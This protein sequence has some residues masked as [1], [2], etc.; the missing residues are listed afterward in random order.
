MFLKI[1][2]EKKNHQKNPCHILFKNALF[3]S[4]ICWFLKT[5]TR[6]S[7][8]HD[9]WSILL[10]Y[11]PTWPSV[12][13]LWPFP[14]QQQPK[15][16]FKGMLFARSSSIDNH[17]FWANEKICNKIFWS[18]IIHTCSTTIPELKIKSCKFFPSPIG[19][20]AL[21]VPLKSILAVWGVS[22]NPGCRFRWF[23]IW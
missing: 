5:V 12:T 1:D 8:N 19:C 15:T 3:S 10:T 14:W 4:E 21:T 16:S 6:N 11:G 20:L 23:M 7:S 17:Q 22:R 18:N 9:S 2:S 13:I